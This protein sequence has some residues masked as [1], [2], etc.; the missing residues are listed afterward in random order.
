MIQL[1]VLWHCTLLGSLSKHNIIEK[2][3]ACLPSKRNGKDVIISSI[4]ELSCWELIVLSTSLDGI[5][6]NE[7]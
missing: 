5:I 6:E 2:V 3:D 4:F 7:A 1:V